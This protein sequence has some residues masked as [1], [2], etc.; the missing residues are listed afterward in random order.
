MTRT[1]KKMTNEAIHMVGVGFVFFGTLL[2]IK[3]SGMC[4][5]GGDLSTLVRY[6]TAGMVSIIGGRFLVWWRV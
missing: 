5:L 4:D 6:A 3:A 2:I 1:M